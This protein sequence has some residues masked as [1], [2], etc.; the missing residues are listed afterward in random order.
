[1]N[2]R[3]AL[4][5]ELSPE[6]RAAKARMQALSEELDKLGIHHA[7]AI[8]EPSETPRANIVVLCS[9]T[10]RTVSG[11]AAMIAMHVE[12]KWNVRPS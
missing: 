11:M 3:E 5:I 2:Q 4:E 9:G 12:E 6:F 10:T 8:R 1:M 7:F